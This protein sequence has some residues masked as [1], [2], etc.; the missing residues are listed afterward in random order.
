M[1]FMRT[2]LYFVLQD[3]TGCANLYADGSAYLRYLGGRASRRS[4]PANDPR[5]ACPA[6]ERRAIQVY[7]VVLLAGTAICLGVECAVSLPALIVLLARA[8]S[9]IGV[10]PVTTVDGGAALAILL[11]WQGLWAWR[12]W[13]RHRRQV[14]ALAR[15]TLA[16]ERR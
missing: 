6:T 11:T 7:S 16:G 13:H 9:E 2:D 3:L 14:Q 10:T 8:V 1:V 5:L 4:T 15:K 12:W